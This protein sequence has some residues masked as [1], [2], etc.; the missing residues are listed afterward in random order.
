MLVRDRE[1]RD[2]LRYQAR[3]LA[4][5]GR[6]KGWEDVERALTRAGRKGAE[7]ALSA[8]LVRFMLNFRCAF[9][10]KNR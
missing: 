4:G 3:Q 1:R 6:Y 9:S 10:A 5:T 7:Q 2:R 8:P